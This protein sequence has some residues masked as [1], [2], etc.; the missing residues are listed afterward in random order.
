MD[1]SSAERATQPD[2]RTDASSKLASVVIPTLNRYLLLSNRLP[3]IAGAGFDEVII[4]DSSTS[5]RDVAATQ[6]LCEGV[7]AVYINSKCGRS[8]A[9][10]RGARAASG[11]WIFY[12]DDDGF[13]FSRLNRERLQEVGP[14]TDYLRFRS[15]FVWIFRRE[16][17]LRI[18]G[19]DEGL[20]AGEDDEISR[21]ALALGS[22]ASAEGIVEGYVHELDP[23]EARSDIL[24]RLRNQFEYGLTAAAFAFRHPSPRS[25]LQGT[26]RKGVDLIAGQSQNGWFFR[27]VGTLVLAVGLAAS[28]FYLLQY[29]LRRRRGRD[30]APTGPPW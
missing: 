4:V 19:Y 10:N 1:E 11:E 3:T 17:L 2:P 21:R 26:L 9:R 15:H 18:G 5:S 30:S 23:N 29:Q 14:D 16:F 27:T 25:V 13:V 12:T 22:G 6:T 7:G 20:V 24:R 28:P 8:A